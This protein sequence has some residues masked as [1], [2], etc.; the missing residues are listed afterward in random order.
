MAQ[1]QDRTVG[2]TGQTPASQPEPE[3]ATE[4]PRRE[5]PAT[6]SPLPLAGLIGLLSL[7]AAAA[8]RRA[9]K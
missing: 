5:L 6:A 2:T 3:A 9:R 7:G 1:P 8:V 4:A